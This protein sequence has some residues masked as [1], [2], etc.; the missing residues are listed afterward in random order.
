MQPERQPR[1]SVVVPSYNHAPYLEEAIGSA[2]ATQ[3]PVEVV[4]VDDGSSDG[5][6]ALLEKWAAEEPRLRVFRQANAGAHVALNRAIWLARGE[7]VTILNSDDAYLP[8]RIEILAEAFAAEPAIAIAGSW[9]E[10]VDTEGKVLGV[11]EGWRT[12]PPPW[13]K[14]GGIGRLG[15][16]ALALLE[17][18]FLSTTSNFAF[19][20]GPA[21]QPVGEP[22]GEPFAALRYAHD[23]DF[24]LDRATAGKFHFVEQPLLRYRVHPSNTIKEGAESGRGLMNFEILWLLARHAHTLCRR[25]QPGHPDLDLI[26]EAAAAMPDF[27]RRDL[28]FTLLALRGGGE[29]PSAAYQA[30]LE[31]EHPLRRRLIAELAKAP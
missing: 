13:Q 10:V 19:R 15:D 22:F 8:G 14:P 31:P 21:G 11:K 18:N 2:L 16:P 23:W 20:R 30:L 9:L 3:L 27:G 24:A 5:S 12:L 25:R 26:R 17:S 6:P 1:V 28:L 4:V 7:L 29:R